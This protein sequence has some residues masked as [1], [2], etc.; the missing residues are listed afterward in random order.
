M[1]L[2]YPYIEIIFG[3]PEINV[4]FKNSDLE[5]CNHGNNILHPLGAFVYTKL[6]I[7]VL[8]RYRGL[9]TNSSS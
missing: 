3:P 1:A 9:K 7:T 2:V 4:T 8:E 6:R 5:A